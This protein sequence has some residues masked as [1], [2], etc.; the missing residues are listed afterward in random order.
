MQVLAQEGKKGKQQQKATGKEGVPP[1]PPRPPRPLPQ[2]QQHAAAQEAA[3]ARREAE[4]SSRE[5][6]SAS[7]Y[8]AGIMSELAVSW[9]AVGKSIS[10]PHVVAGMGMRGVPVACCCEW[11]C[12]GACAG[13][14]ESWEHQLPTAG[15]PRPPRRRLPRTRCRRRVG[16]TSRCR[17]S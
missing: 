2:R 17:S 15:V 12:C 9:A 16:R 11:R 1:R 8:L 5:L 14:P 4:A 3:D 13:L 10:C 7:D 6:G